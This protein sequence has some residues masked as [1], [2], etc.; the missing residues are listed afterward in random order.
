[1]IIKIIAL[2]S[3]SMKQH[4]AVYQGKQLLVYFD[5]KKLIPSRYKSSEYQIKKLVEIA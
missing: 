1:M 4:Y 5:D 3:R 2:F